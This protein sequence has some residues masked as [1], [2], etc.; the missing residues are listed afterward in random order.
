MTPHGVIQNE[1]VLQQSEGSS[2][3][4]LHRLGRSLGPLVKA[5]AFGMTPQQ[6]EIKLNQLRRS[7]AIQHGMN[8]AREGVETEWL[9]KKDGIGTEKL[10]IYGAVAISRHEDD[11][12]SGTYSG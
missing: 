6:A 10:R 8:F 5:R 12:Q 11:G 3:N 2:T 4:R 9:L 1:A 7:L